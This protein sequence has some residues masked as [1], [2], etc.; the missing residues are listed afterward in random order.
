MMRAQAISS[1]RT[2]E[3]VKLEKG[4]LPL[5]EERL[6]MRQLVTY[7]PNKT[8]PIHRWFSYIRRGSRLRWWTLSYGNLGLNRGNL[9]FSILSSDAA[10]R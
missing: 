8:V 9:V 4:F 1:S 10:Q 6:G 2:D 3:R 5:M 7:V